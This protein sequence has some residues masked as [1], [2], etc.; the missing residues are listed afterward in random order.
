MAVA[1]DQVPVA[2]R[3]LEQAEQPVHALLSHLAARHAVEVGDVVEEL[4]AG[5]VGVDERLLIEVAQPRLGFHRLGED[6]EALDQS[7]ARRRRHQPAQH[8]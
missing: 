2:V 1:A 6:V 7:L 4:A 5:E 3:E 8:A